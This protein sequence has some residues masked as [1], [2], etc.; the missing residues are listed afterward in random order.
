MPRKEKGQ[1]SVTIP[2]W[3]GDIAEEYF[4]THR[5]ELEKKGVMSVSALIKLWVIESSR[6][7]PS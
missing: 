3:V 4:N 6:Q 5:Q 1:T 2:I 7:P